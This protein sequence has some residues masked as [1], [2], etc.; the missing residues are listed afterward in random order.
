MVCYTLA[1]PGFPPYLRDYCLSLRLSF[2]SRRG[3]GAPLA[4]EPVCDQ[5]I[6][7]N[8]VCFGYSRH[9]WYWDGHYEGPSRQELGSLVT[10]ILSHTQR[11]ILLPLQMSPSAV[12]LL[13]DVDTVLATLI[14][15]EHQRCLLYYAILWSDRPR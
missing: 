13:K 5:A 11:F 6:Y 2:P 3:R 15:T 8:A 12:H 9:H 4:P 1:G 7:S 14:E 10:R